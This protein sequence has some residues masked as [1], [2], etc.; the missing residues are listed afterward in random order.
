MRIP[1]RLC[2]AS[3]H[4]GNHDHDCLGTHVSC[5]A[6]TKH[7]LGECQARRYGIH[8]THLG[9]SAPIKYRHVP[10]G[11][12]APPLQSCQVQISS[13]LCRRA[14]ASPCAPWLQTCLPVREGSGVATCP[15]PPGPPPSREGLRCHHMSCGSRPTS[16]C[17]K[18]LASPHAP[19]HQARHPARMSF[20]VA[21]CPAA[22]DPPPGAGGP[23][24][25]H[26][27]RGP[28]PLR[29]ARA[30]QRCLT[31]DSSWPHQARGAGS[32]LNAYKTSHMWRMASIKCV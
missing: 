15:L 13:K 5:S 32:A 26:V 28:Q 2:V 8:V 18:A 1:P 11:G 14:L 6:I 10:D 20:G 29:H 24:R 4:F 23:R 16:R 31:S 25:H 12:T 17:R 27:P 30:F 19:W 7:W 9:A 3:R 22:L 21:T